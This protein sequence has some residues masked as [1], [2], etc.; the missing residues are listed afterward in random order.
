[1]DS[2]RFPGHF[3]TACQKQ[4]WRQHKNCGKK[5]VSKGLRG[6]VHD[7]YWAYPYVPSQNLPKQNSDG[8]IGERSS[9]FVDPQPARPYSSA[10]Q[11]QVSLLT[12]DRD[13]DYFLF[14]ELDQPVRVARQD[15]SMRYVFRALRTRAWSNDAM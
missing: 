13:A 5:K 2:Y 3:C 1:M 6:T 8:T 9:G 4:D 12:A 14:D 10:L 7:H 11:R 15:E